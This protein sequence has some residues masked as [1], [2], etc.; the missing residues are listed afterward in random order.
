MIDPRHMIS[1]HHYSF[2]VI[3]SLSNRDIEILHN[4][5]H[6]DVKA[7]KARLIDPHDHDKD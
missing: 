1:E 7:G 2:A 5:I 4:K 6:E 3:H